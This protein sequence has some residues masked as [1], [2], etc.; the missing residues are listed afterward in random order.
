MND[1]VQPI[2]RLYMRRAAGWGAVMAPVVRAPG[3]PPYWY[4]GKT[5]SPRVP[6][7]EG[8]QG[9]FELGLPTVVGIK[10][11]KDGAGSNLAFC[12]LF[13]ALCSHLE[14]GKTYEPRKGAL[15]KPF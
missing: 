13:G 8:N 15:G 1:S 10:M 7:L 11:H 2:P 5:G 6:V 14:P 9:R 4:G 3:A 12:H